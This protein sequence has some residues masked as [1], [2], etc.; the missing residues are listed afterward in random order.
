MSIG[1]GIATAAAW[2]SVAIIFSAL[3]TCSY[4]TDHDRNQTKEDCF[5]AGGT[6]D[7]WGD[8]CQ[9]VKTTVLP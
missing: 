1:K 5:Q 2:L 8:S 3:A 7:S 9:P 4:F 6:W